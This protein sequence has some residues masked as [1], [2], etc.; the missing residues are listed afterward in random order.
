MCRRFV[1][2]VPSPTFLMCRRFVPDVPIGSIQISTGQKQRFERPPPPFH[3]RAAAPTRY[4]GNASRLK[5]SLGSCAGTGVYAAYETVERCFIIFGLTS[6]SLAKP[7]IEISLERVN[8]P[9]GEVGPDALDSLGREHA[10][11]EQR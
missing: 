11:A 8:V 6:L 10:G 5:S 1:P 4:I 2:D 9:A 7:S 3:R